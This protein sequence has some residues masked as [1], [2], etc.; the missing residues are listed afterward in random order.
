MLTLRML[1][2][3]QLLTG[4]SVES[5]HLQPG[6]SY[7][8]L[9]SADGSFVARWKGSNYRMQIALGCLYLTFKDEYDT[10]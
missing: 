3:K 6:R 9:D 2:W 1:R 8:N 5:Y 10:D 7:T 4:L